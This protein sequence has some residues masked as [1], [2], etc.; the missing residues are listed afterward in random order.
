MFGTLFLSRR[1]FIYT[2]FCVRVSVN[3]FCRAS[4]AIYEISRSFVLATNAG[5]RCAWWRKIWKDFRLSHNFTKSVKQSGHWLY[6][7]HNECTNVGRT[8]T[9]ALKQ[10]CSRVDVKYAMILSRI[11][12]HYIRRIIVHNN[13][14]NNQLIRIVKGDCCRLL[15]LHTDLS[16]YC[17]HART[18]E[19]AIL[20]SIAS[21]ISVRVCIYIYDYCWQ[22]AHIIY[23]ERCHDHWWRR[24]WRRLQLS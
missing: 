21:S 16:C 12:S 1:D 4:S 18:R 6:D 10:S 9:Q 5:V 14:N 8:F 20:A 22:N 11:C 17:G 19:S 3:G 2:I 15:L 24:L 13:W 7:D 23:I